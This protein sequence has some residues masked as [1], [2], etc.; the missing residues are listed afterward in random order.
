MYKISL[1]CFLPLYVNL[2]FI[3]TKNSNIKKGPNRYFRTE[4]YTEKKHILS[5]CFT[6]SYP[7][8]HSAPAAAALAS[9]PACVATLP[10]LCFRLAPRFL[11]SFAVR[12]S[13]LTC[14]C[15]CQSSCPNPSE[16]H[17]FPKG[18]SPEPALSLLRFHSD[19]LYPVY[20]SPSPKQLLIPAVLLILVCLCL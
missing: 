18:S 19:L 1:Y 16:A 12:V 11:L 20:L 2:K 14:N 15:S 13:S 5:E 9:F 3:S 7:P 4:K 6:V 17:C 8:V 10:G